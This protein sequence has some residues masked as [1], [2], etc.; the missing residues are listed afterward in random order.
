M[1]ADV[2]SALWVLLGAVGFI[3]LIA[4]ANVANL[5]LARGTVREREI[6]MRFALGARRGRILRQLLTESVLL[7]VVGGAVGGLLSFYLIKSFRAFA[8]RLL[9]LTYLVELDLRVLA[10][11]AVITLATGILFGLLPALQTATARSAALH[12]SGRTTAGGTRHW[13]GRSL[14]AGEFALSL[15]LMIG[16]ALL[17]RSFARLQSVDP[18]FDPSRL[19][20]AQVSIPSGAYPRDTNIVVFW[21]ELLRR[22]GSIPGI[23]SAAVTLSAPPD[24]LMLTNPFT[25]EGQSYDPSRP[26]QLA[27]EMTVSPDYFQTLGIPLL[28][29]RVFEPSD[30]NRKQ[31]VIIINRT[32]ADRYFPG[33]DPVGKWIQTGDPNPSAPKEIIIGVVG[34]VKYSGLGSEAVPQLYVAY[35]SGDWAYF[36]RSMYLA[37]R[38][39]APPESVV[40]GIRREL[41][42]LDPGIPL[43][44]VATMEQMLGTSVAEQRFRTLA[45]AA[46]AGLALVLSCCGI[47][48]VTAY[49]V[50]QRTREIGIRVALGATRRGIL[51][52]VFGQGFTMAVFGI[53]VGMLGGIAVSRGVSSLLFGISPADPV[54]FVGTA[55]LLLGV[56]ILA[57]YIPARRAT[58]VEPTIAL[59]HE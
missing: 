26:L 1:V 38:S 23:D 15:M 7:S 31:G 16:A 25:A 37:V 4:A 55:V 57:T 40:A 56:G 53:I 21:D 5:L 10:F 13:L 51:R 32:L 35:S 50:A 36:S 2:Q 48:G 18:G 9:P 46:F 11:T 27:E 28:R 34:D 14:V 54:S 58:L 8:S 29:G 6:S 3:L 41:Q 17:L 52:L 45:I 19:I 33:Q 47:Y 12:G 42:R 20:V 39:S 44:R 49:M 59:R 43:G 22:V 24:R 30:R